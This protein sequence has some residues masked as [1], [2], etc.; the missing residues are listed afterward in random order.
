[1]KTEE[2]VR[3]SVDVETGAEELLATLVD[4]GVEYIFA[5]LG[6]DYPALVEAMAKSRATGW[7]GSTLAFA[8]TFR[9]VCIARCR[10]TRRRRAGL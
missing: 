7:I 2:P 10:P 6:T 9:P 8:S 1:M 5:N 4:L 3:Q